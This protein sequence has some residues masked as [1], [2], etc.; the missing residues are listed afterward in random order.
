VKA[1]F[2]T[3]N[4][5]H[6]G[7][8]S[9]FFTT[10]LLLNS[11]LNVKPTLVPF[12]GGGPAVNALVAGQVDYMCGDGVVTAPQLAAGTIKV[13]AIA[14]MERNPALPNVPTSVE[15]GL[16]EFSGVCLERLIRPE[17]NAEA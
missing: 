6:A 9:V 17:G 4:V 1:N 5:S 2:T 12:N 7:V 14:A 10:C 3:L 16:P 13:Y 11:I 8:G 15:A